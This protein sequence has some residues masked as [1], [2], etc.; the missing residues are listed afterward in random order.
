M[1]NLKK[2]VKCTPEEYAE[3]Q[4]EG[5]LDPDVIYITKQAVESNF[6]V[7]NIGNGQTTIRGTVYPTIPVATA[8]SIYAKL[9]AG[10]TIKCHWSLVLP[11]D[12]YIIGHNENKFLAIAP[13]GK[14]ISY[15]WTSSSVQDISPS[16][17]EKYRHNIVIS[18]TT[19]AGSWN[20][21]FS[22]DNDVP[23]AYTQLSQ[24]GHYLYSKEV[25]TQI[26][27]TG[28]C[29]H[30]LVSYFITDIKAEEDNMVTVGMYKISDGTRNTIS[31]GA[32][33]VTDYI[34]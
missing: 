31:T 18:A 24:I 28:L 14:V 29:V 32:I 6:Q 10:K 22:F 3:W 2:I 34:Q 7:I 5:T 11:Y 19:S 33:E 21:Q 23:T 20:Y 26:M 8:Q 9:V 15:E 16:V 1:A 13:N 25:G 17:L 12:F 4:E 30:N 27:A